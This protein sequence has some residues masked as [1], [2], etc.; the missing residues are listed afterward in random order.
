MGA[1]MLRA[2]RHT[3]YAWHNLPTTYT[4][5]ECLPVRTSVIL[6]AKNPVM[7]DATLKNW[8]LALHNH[9]LCKGQ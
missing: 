8:L 3:A 5:R 4:K 7:E 6:P 9:G 2:R 1:G